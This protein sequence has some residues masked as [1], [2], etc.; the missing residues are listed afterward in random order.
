[1]DSEF[2]DIEKRLNELGYYKK[3]WETYSGWISRIEETGTAQVQLEALFP[4]LAYHYRYRF[5]PAGLSE[6]EQSELK[7]MT[8][9][10]LREI[11]T[12]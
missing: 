7:S 3:D 8:R 4:I 10:W 12:L 11:D 1:M 5:D 6:V 2:Y 9:A